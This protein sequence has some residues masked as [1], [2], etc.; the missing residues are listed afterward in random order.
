MAK[1]NKQTKDDHGVRSKPLQIRS[2]L[3]LPSCFFIFQNR[4]RVWPVF[5]I[6]KK[7]KYEVDYWVLLSFLRL[8]QISPKVTEKKQMTI[9]VYVVNLTRF[10]LTQFYRVFLINFHLCYFNGPTS[11]LIGLKDSS[12]AMELGFTGFYLVFKGFTRLD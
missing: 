3:V 12:S 5:F 8:L 9:V 1:I 6:E 2:Y 10:A 4:S 7:R 11:N